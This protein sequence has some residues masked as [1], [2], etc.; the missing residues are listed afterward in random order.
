MFSHLGR[1]AF[2]SRS[3]NFENLLDVLQRLV[4]RGNT[5]LVIEHQLDVIKAADYVI[6]L[7]SGDGRNIMVDDISAL[8]KIF[9]K[10]T[11]EAQK[12]QLVEDLV[13]VRV[14]KRVEAIEAVP[15]GADEI[16][17]CGPR[18]RVEDRLLQV[19]RV[20]HLRRRLRDVQPA[21]HQLNLA[22]ST[23]PH[24]VAASHLKADQGGAHRRRHA[25]LGEH[26]SLI[27]L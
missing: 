19:R 4:E 9:M 1:S 16:A 27:M 11:Q 18:D 15:N 2:E 25:Q 26:A 5:V 23:R 12:S 22:P 7:G 20:R 3:T 17:L 6:D 24:R 13:H 8:P 14:A 21:Q 10:E